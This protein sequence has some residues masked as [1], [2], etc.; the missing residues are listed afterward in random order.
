MVNRPRGLPPSKDL[1]PSN[2]SAT[3]RT[4]LIE[5]AIPVAVSPGLGIEAVGVCLER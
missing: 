1:T 4:L 5:I 2:A 3:L